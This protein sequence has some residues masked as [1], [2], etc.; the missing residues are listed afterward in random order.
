MINLTVYSSAVEGQ[1]VTINGEMSIEISQG[2]DLVFSINSDSVAEL[3]KEGVDLA[4]KFKDGNVLHA[5]NFFYA[6][7]P[8][9]ESV[10]TFSDALFT[11]S[12]IEAAFSDD[13]LH[14]VHPGNIAKHQKKQHNLLSLTGKHSMR[15]KVAAVQDAPFVYQFNLDDSFPDDGKIKVLLNNEPIPSWMTL[16]QIAPRQ[17]ILTGVPTEGHVGKFNLQIVA[18]VNDGNETAD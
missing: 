4:V 12:E 3:A 18:E 8:H 14:Q 13:A 2:D 1:K 11:A 9:V 6:D 5:V 17:Y 16:K 15:T 7:R 10:L